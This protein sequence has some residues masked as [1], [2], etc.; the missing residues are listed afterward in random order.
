MLQ[1]RECKTGTDVLE[2][3][4]RTRAYF[5]GLDKDYSATAKLGAITHELEVIK[6]ERDQ[7]RATV[8]NLRAINVELMNKIAEIRGLTRPGAD[9]LPSPVEPMALKLSVLTVE[10]IQRAVCAHFNISRANLLSQQR[11]KTIV[12]PRQ[13]A[14]Y[15][16]Q[17]HTHNSLPAIGRMFAGRDH[18][19]VLHAVKRVLSKLPGNIQLD[20]DL[21]AIL[22]LLL[23]QETHTPG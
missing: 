3:V 12:W 20:S 4:K 19:T 14:M 23:T 17:Q 7:Y 10:K 16:C 5:S 18:T 6:A 1:V 8:D 22:A 2:N 11:C 13:I 21:K 15:L 9:M